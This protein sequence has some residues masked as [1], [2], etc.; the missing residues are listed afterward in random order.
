MLLCFLTVRT[1]TNTYKYKIY[2]TNN[3]DEQNWQGFPS[4]VMT[5][6]NVYHHNIDESIISLSFFYIIRHADK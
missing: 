5:D 1:N 3:K 2:N 6:L 4:N